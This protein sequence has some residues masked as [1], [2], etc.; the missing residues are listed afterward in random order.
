MSYLAFNTPVDTSNQVFTKDTRS[1]MWD[2]LRGMSL[3]NVRAIWKALDEC[4]DEDYWTT[5]WDA[6]AGIS[7]KEW[8]E[9]VYAVLSEKKA[10][11]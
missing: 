10:S 11:Q 6:D 4:K 8:A 1:R 5:P 2:K 3:P 9:A 7:M